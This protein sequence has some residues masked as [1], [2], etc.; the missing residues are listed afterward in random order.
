MPGVFMVAARIHS[1]LLRNI[2][3]GLQPFL[4]QKWLKTRMDIA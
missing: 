1:F 3:A 2:H 4:L